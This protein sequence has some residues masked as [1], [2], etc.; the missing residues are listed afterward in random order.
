MCWGRDGTWQKAVIMVTSA[1]L[2]LLAVAPQGIASAAAS[3]AGSTTTTTVPAVGATTT[4]V[5][6]TGAA[7]AT[8]K[9][10][11]ATT[12]TTKPPL[13]KV[14]SSITDGQ[15]VAALLS[16]AVTLDAVGVDKSGVQSAVALTQQKL[17]QEAVTIRQLRQA[18][19]RASERAATLLARART[20]QAA[21][22]SLDQAVKQAVLFL[23]VN[24]P[25]NV[26]VNPSAGN[27]LAYA[28]DYADTAITPNGILDTRSFDARSQEQALSEARKAAAAADRATAAAT[29]A[30]AAETSEQGRLLAILSSM[31]AATAAVASQVAADHAALASQAGVELLSA[32]SL[33]FTPK[34]SIPP[35]L[36][37]TAV[38]LEWAFAELGQ[39]YVWGATGPNSFDCSG[40]TQFVWRQAG[41]NIPRVASAQYAWTIPVP[42]SQLLPGDLVFYGTTDIHH[43]GI[44]I[45][46]GLMINAPHTGTVVQVSS[47]W[48]SDL[49]GFGRVHTAG[50][51]VPSHQSPNQAHPAKA[52]VV[53]TPGPVPSQKKPPPGWKPKPGSS[54]PLAVYPGPPTTPAP[55]TTVPSTTTSTTSTPPT[56]PPTTIQSAPPTTQPTA[57]TVSS[58]TTALPPP[59]T[60]PTAP[61]LAP[62]TDGASTTTTTST[63]TTTTS[64][65]PGG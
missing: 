41:V 32:T 51:P 55:T 30:I 40:L 42:L 11:G 37:T 49:A 52:Q 61:T 1:A 35:P 62:S 16:Q 63:S 23:Y 24:G 13:P 8:G 14:S 2:I 39:P 17:D 15:S 22:S 45:G 25:S 5:P 28:I 48:W 27:A 10:A 60:T 53:A 29:A 7:K 64:T 46:N 54:T 57:T 47:I 20:A 33:Q 44:Y 6:A 50:T 18:A 34:G 4:T 12:T 43:V 31:S 58:S 36:S 65:L 19:A 26:T 9:P 59:T 56:Q 38:A 3:A 21:Y